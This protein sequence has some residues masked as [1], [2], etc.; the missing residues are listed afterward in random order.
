MDHYT[1][2]TL[3]LMPNL[4]YFLASVMLLLSVS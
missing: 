4:C 3:V 1:R 2:Q